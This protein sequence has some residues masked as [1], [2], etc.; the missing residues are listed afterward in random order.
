MSEWHN[1]LEQLA[2]E[3]SEAREDRDRLIAET[4]KANAQFQEEIENQVNNLEIETL[5]I[6]MNN[7]L[8][9]KTGSVTS[10]KSWE[11]PIASDDES[12]E[13]L[14]DGDFISVLL[15]WEENGEREI[16]VDLGRDDSG[17][18]LE[19]NG[20]EIPMEKESLQAAL[21]Y[22]IKEELDLV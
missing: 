4:D 2:Q 12:E 21:L 14:D 10:S 1:N 3:L 15:E 19:V 11:E 17:L 7:K 6:E 22:A 20:H 18:Y 13:E 8:L 5:L 16:A 9:T